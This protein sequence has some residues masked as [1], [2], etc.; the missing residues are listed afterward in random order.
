MLTNQS[1][2]T[3]VNETCRYDNDLCQEY[4][5]YFGN[6]CQK[7]LNITNNKPFVRKL[8][9]MLVNSTQFTRS[10]LNIQAYVAYNLSLSLGLTMKI[11][12]PMSEICSACSLSNLIHC[13]GSISSLLIADRH[14]DSRRN[15]MSFICSAVIQYLQ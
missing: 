7:K 2:S 3:P 6:G 11:V 8:F 1:L 10:I 13:H 9:T 15:N 12:V 14:S 4:E 5:Y